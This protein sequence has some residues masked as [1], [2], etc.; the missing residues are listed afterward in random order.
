MK[1]TDDM[2]MAEEAV[3]LNDTDT[4]R[5]EGVLNQTCMVWPY[6]LFVQNNR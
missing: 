2:M 5:N 6:F 1:T 3:M 4:K